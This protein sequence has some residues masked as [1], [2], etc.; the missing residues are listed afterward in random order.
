MSDSKVT[1]CSREDDD[2][3]IRWHETVINGVRVF[4]SDRFN[5][6]DDNVQTTHKVPAPSVGA[7]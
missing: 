4:T 2:E 3:Y 5:E 7:A 6:P 1:I